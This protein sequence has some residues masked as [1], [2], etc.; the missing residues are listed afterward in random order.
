M[1]GWEERARRIAH[2]HLT[3]DYNPDCRNGKL[4][5]EDGHSYDCNALMGDIEAALGE[6]F[7]AGAAAER[8]A[9]IDR[10]DGLMPL[11]EGPTL[12]AAKGALEHGIRYIR[13]SPYPTQ[14]PRK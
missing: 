4:L 13:M 7:R 6:A 5:E 3:R 9:T 10:L 14:N 8:E 1:T 2:D 12:R 11:G